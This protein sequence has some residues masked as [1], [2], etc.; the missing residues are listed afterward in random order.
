MTVELII[1]F[2]D[3]TWTTQKTTI[4]NSAKGDEQI[5]SRAK[6]NMSSFLNNND[7]AYIGLYHYEN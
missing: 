4:D 1:C 3:K 7:I 6:N 5:L 2:T